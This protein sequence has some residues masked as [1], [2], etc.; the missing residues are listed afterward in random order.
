[1]TSCIVWLSILV[2]FPFQILGLAGTN[3]EHAACKVGGC[4]WE[5]VAQANESILPTDDG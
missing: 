4:N 3:D 2:D 1:M 5:P